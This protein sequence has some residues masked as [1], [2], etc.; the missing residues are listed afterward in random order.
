MGVVCGL[1]GKYNP[2][3]N[4]KGDRTRFMILLMFTAG[5]LQALFEHISK[6]LC[7]DISVQLYLFVSLI[8]M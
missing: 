7:G 8:S 1:V 3:Q 4:T 5:L 6:A 2:V